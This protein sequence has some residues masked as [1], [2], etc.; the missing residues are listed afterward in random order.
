MTTFDPAGTPFT[1]RAITFV[2]AR[3]DLKLERSFEV[4]ARRARTSVADELEVL[5]SR[6][7]RYRAT[8]L[9]VP[10]DR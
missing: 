3:V 10:G 6:L 9:W 4:I 1:V 2:Y 7:P 8:M 5:K